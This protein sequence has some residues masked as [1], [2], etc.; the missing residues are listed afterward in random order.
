MIQ[1]LLT[2]KLRPKELRHMILPSRISKMF[3]NGLSQ[4]VLLSGPPGCGK[5]T[6]ANN[7][8]LAV[9]ERGC[10]AWT[11]SLDRWLRDV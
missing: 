7:L 11:L 3:E 2:E 1:D 9:L 6:L 8:R 4:N 10:N 5:T